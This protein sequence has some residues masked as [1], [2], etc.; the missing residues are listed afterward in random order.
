MKLR[1]APPSSAR[2]ASSS[3]RDGA[4]LWERALR[5]AGLPTAHSAGYTPRPQDQLRPGAADRR[6]VDRRVRRHRAPR[7]RRAGPRP[8]PSRPAPGRA[9]RRAAR[10]HRRDRRRRAPA[11]RRVAA[12][13]RHV[14]HVGALERP[15]LAPADIAA[16]TAAARRRPT[17]DR[18]RTQGP[19]SHRRHPPARARSPPRRHRAVAWWPNSPPS[20]GRC[21]RPSW[22]LSR[23]PTSTPS[24]CERFGHTNGSAT[25]ATGAR[26]SR[27]PP[28]WPRTPAGWAHE[29]GIALM[30]DTNTETG[31]A[32]AE[33]PDTALQDVF[34]ED[35][36]GS[37]RPSSRCTDGRGRGATPPPARVARWS[38]TPQGHW[39]GSIGRHRRRQRR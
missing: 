25:T 8:A 36:G 39:S 3:H 17:D 13:S 32:A 29:K 23:S 16:A 26:C 5:K 27:C 4:R 33:R 35:R 34:N 7:R 14:V 31:G 10:R 1:S 11:R 18:A 28:R 6:R 21:A 22:R 20:V 12:G 15:I 2:S 38:A 30:D 24:T 9:H 37:R 19:S